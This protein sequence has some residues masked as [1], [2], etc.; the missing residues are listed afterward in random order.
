MIDSLTFNPVVS[1]TVSWLLVAIAV[2]MLVWKELWARKPE[3]LKIA[4]VLL[5]TFGLMGILLRP[6][7]RSIKSSVSVLVTQN[8]NAAIVDSLIQEHRGAKIYTAPGVRITRSK[9]V[10]PLSSWHELRDVEAIDVITGEGLPPHAMDLLEGQTFVFIPAS[11]GSGFLT[12]EVAPTI[13]S[14]RLNA[15]TGVYAAAKPT[16]LRIDGTGGIADSLNVEDGVQSVA[17]QFKPKTSGPLTLTLTERAGQDTKAYRLGI[18]VQE[19]LRLSILMLQDYPTFEHSYLKNFLSRDHAITIRYRLSRNVFRYEY[20]NS[21]SALQ[22]A[23]TR[24]MLKNFDVVV[25]T[26]DVLKTLSKSELTALESGVRDGM[27]ILVTGKGNEPFPFGPELQVEKLTTDTVQIRG[28]SGLKTIVHTTRFALA[29]KQ[30][31]NKVLAQREKVLAGYYNH[32]FGRVGYTVLR[33]SYPLLLR[34]DSLAYANLWAPIIESVSRR[35]HASYEIRILSS[36]PYLRDEPLHLE[37]LTSSGPPTIF[38]DSVR[39]PVIEDYR[40]ANRW[41]AT[42]WPS[43][44]GWN[45]IRS[46]DDSIL[47]PFFVNAQE[48]WPGLQ[49]KRNVEGTAR[50]AASEIS[51]HKVTQAQPLNPLLFYGAFLLGMSMLWLLPKMR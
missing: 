30:P 14:N 37:I 9:D 27:G 28:P 24:E 45:E 19:P 22:K 46:A 49:K 21:N 20:I 31:L 12:L 18:N 34:G 15:L 36:M 51:K 47:L 48:E 13:K 41:K 44:E 35:A 38:Y 16:L 6:A 42:I 32:D 11:H 29:S 39:I 2:G 3:A 8:Y 26:P 4:A 43:G 25:T 10:T 7:L 40:F 1:I 23:I 33:E 17:F 50:I 5:A